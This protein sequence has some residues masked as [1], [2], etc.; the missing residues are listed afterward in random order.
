MMCML[1]LK[2]I[3]GFTVKAVWKCAKLYH[4]G[5]M[6]TQAASCSR[7]GLVLTYMTASFYRP[8]NTFS[9]CVLAWQIQMIN[10]AGDAMARKVFNKIPLLIIIGLVSICEVNF[11]FALVL[12][13]LSK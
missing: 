12:F 11:L 7:L 3:Y 13:R 6:P 5:I 9:V 4:R 8:F 1:E 10:V 2:M